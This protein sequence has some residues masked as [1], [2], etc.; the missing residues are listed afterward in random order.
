M[1]RNWKK[2]SLLALLLLLVWLARREVCCPVIAALPTCWALSQLVRPNSRQVPALTSECRFSW[3]PEPSI[4]LEIVTHL[5][6][7]VS[8]RKGSGVQ[9]GGWLEIFHHR[10]EDGWRWRVY[11]PHCEDDGSW[12]HGLWRPQAAH[13]GWQEGGKGEVLLQLLSMNNAMNSLL[14]MAV[15]LTACFVPEQESYPVAGGTGSWRYILLLAS[16]S[17][18]CRL[19]TKRSVAPCWRQGWLDGVAGWES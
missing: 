5:I 1:P 18:W 13:Q 12:W 9:H 15:F 17:H 10:P 6:V 4:P 7:L 3:S 11:H 19:W 14:R 2:R 8:T 16:I